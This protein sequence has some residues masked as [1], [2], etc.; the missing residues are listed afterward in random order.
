MGAL[1]IPGHCV[2]TMSPQHIPIGFGLNR[3]RVTVRRV[4]VRVKVEVVLEARLVVRVIG[5]GGGFTLE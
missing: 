4:K 1:C 5:L 3:V 2:G